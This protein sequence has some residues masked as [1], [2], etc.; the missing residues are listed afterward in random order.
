[1]QRSEI[2][3]WLEEHPG[4][5]RG[6]DPS[7]IVARCEHEVR[8][9]AA[10]DAWLAAKAHV[11]RRLH[12][13]EG[14]WGLHA[15]EAHVAREICPRLAS[16]LRSREPHPEPGDEVHLAGNALLDILTPEARELT[17]QWI[18][19]LAAEQ[20]HRT[21]EQIVRFT[22][23]RGR[24][25]IREGKVSQEGRWEATGYYPE[26]AAQIARIL[27]ADYQRRALCD[28]AAAGIR[29]FPF[30]RDTGR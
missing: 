25:L 26:V 30:G 8:R 17:A 21:W 7:Q 4:A 24:R 10:E 3:N 29:S 14:Q 16:E 28:P 22:R 6:D 12:Q 15:S 23:R 13:W 2:L 20:E 18:L 11:E 1:M 5:V 27:A 9:H 19:E